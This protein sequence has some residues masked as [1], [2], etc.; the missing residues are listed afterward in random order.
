MG[1]LMESRS[2]LAARGGGAPGAELPAEPY[3]G[4]ALGGA[5][6]AQCVPVFRRSTNVGFN[7]WN[8]FPLANPVPLKRH[9]TTPGVTA[10]TT[11]DST[12]TAHAG[13]LSDTPALADPTPV[14]NA[15]AISNKPTAVDPAIA[16]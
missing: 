5:Q 4:S 8:C 15:N 10:A 7:Q 3:G 11:D 12:T 6:G 14:A 9:Q 2:P 16:I 13:A 1:V